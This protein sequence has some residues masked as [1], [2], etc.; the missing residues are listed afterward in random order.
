MADR[1]NITKAVPSASV[2]S[3]PAIP[4]TTFWWLSFQTRKERTSRASATPLAVL[5]SKSSDDTFGGTLIKGGE[6]EPDVGPNDEERGQSQVPS[7]ASLAHASP[8]VSFS[9]GVPSYGRTIYNL[10][11]NS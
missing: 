10:C 3:S 9:S 4:A 6:C 5:L 8:S 7:H 2:R 1:N 11:T